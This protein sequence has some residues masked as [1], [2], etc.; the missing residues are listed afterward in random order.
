MSKVREDLVGVVWYTVDGGEARSLKAGDAVPEGVEL[1]DHLLA[2]LRLPKSS[3]Q[4]AGNASTEA[5]QEYAKSQGATDDD[6]DGLSRDDI[7][8]QYGK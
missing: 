4:P 6:I 7:R 3:D 2:D 5:W 1:G 8:A